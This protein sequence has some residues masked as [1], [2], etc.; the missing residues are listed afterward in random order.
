[1]TAT[2]IQPLPSA[3]ISPALTATAS[4]T[5][6]RHPPAGRHCRRRHCRPCRRSPSSPR[7]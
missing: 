2:T 4:P 7:C 6:T 5:D 3:T 1:M